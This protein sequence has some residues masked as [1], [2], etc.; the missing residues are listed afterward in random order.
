MNTIKNTTLDKSING[1]IIDVNLAFI[2][3][4]KYESDSKNRFKIYDALENI[5]TTVDKARNSKE[6]EYLIKEIS[7]TA[8]KLKDVTFSSDV[9]DELDKMSEKIAKV[10]FKFRDGAK[11]IIPYYCTELSRS[12]KPYISDARY[13]YYTNY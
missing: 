8:Q 5:I 1:I 6:K 2:A 10:T 12:I 7:T 11:N 9:F 4:K 13:D 3:N